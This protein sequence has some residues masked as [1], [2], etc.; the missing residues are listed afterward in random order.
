MDQGVDLG[1]GG[2]VVDQ[3]INQMVDQ[4]IVP[5][6]G[7]GGV[8]ITKYWDCKYVTVKNSLCTTAPNA[9]NIVRSTCLRS[10]CLLALLRSTC[11]F[12]LCPPE[13]PLLPF[14]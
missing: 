10:P 13:E 7:P 4:G 9:S 3:G 11:L 14:V 2:Q 5:S 1:M 8:L 6:G 12:C